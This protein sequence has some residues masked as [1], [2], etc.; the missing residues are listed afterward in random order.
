MAKI[1]I[2][3]STSPPTISQGRLKLLVTSRPYDDIQ[4]E[5]QKTLDANNV[6]TIRLRGEEKNDQIHQE[7]NLVIQKR[8]KEL[9]EDL[10][11]NHRI[12]GQLEARLLE[13]KHRTYL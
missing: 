2:Q 13:M 3:V 1:Y 7:I 11:L 6:P 12:K 10:K 9:A 5:F 4:A 8:V